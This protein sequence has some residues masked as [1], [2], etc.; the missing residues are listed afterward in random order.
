VA[1]AAERGLVVA[2]LTA[3]GHPE[4]DGWV[5]LALFRNMAFDSAA[6]LPTADA[7][8]AGRPGLTA[9][10]FAGPDR[11]GR[12]RFPGYSYRRELADLHP[13]TTPDGSPT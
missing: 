12:W 7:L 5:L 9:M 3:P 13:D 8:A 10:G 4:K 2:A 1:H 6:H 11:D